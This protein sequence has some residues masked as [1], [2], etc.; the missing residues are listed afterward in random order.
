MDS[1]ARFVGQEERNIVESVPLFS[2]GLWMMDGCW[3]SEQ[4][5]SERGRGATGG[6]RSG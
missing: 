4:G 3:M 1:R 5:T 6:A 2:Y